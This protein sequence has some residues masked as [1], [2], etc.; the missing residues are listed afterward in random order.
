MRVLLE[1]MS[2]SVDFEKGVCLVCFETKSQNRPRHD[3]ADLVYCVFLSV[4][5][6]KGVC[7]VCFETWSQ[8]RPSRHP[9]QNRHG[10]I[11]AKG[12]VFAWSVLR[13][14]PVRVY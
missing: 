10:G 1:E 2:S 8:N 9:S 5:F 4:D 12:P 14:L 3:K 11:R 6:E 7:L 13:I